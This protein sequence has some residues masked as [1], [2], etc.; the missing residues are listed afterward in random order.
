MI[1]ANVNELKLFVDENWP[2]ESFDF[3][4]NLMNFSNLNSLTLIV[5]EN[6]HLSPELIRNLRLLFKKTPHIET[7]SIKSGQSPLSCKITLE[8]IFQIVPKQVKHLQVMVKDFDDIIMIIDRLQHLSSI[9]IQIVRV[10]ARGFSESRPAITGKRE[11][12]TCQKMDPF[13]QMWLGKTNTNILNDN[14]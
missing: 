13:L 1:F 7:L 5:A 3:L 4:S 6:R 10:M 8:E 2:D 9:Q 11:G 12:S 14:E